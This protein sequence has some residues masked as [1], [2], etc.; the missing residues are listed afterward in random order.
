[1]AAAYLEAAAAEQKSATAAA[2]MARRCLEMSLKH[3]GFKGR[4][5]E[6]RIDAL[7][8]DKRTGPR[9]LQQLHQLR[10]SGN[11]AAH[12]DIVDGIPLFKIDGEDLDAA[13]DSLLDLFDDYFVT[14]SVL[15]ERKRKH[16]AKD[17]EARAARAEARA[18][19]KPSL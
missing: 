9:L 13:F 7:E 5:L 19:A 8:N 10:D 3:L 18:A 6:S 12:G 17:A 16:D 4:D 1:L 14:P 11:W 2:L 15:E